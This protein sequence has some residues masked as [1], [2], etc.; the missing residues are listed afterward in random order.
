M[1]E[2]PI[3]PHAGPTIDAAGQLTYVGD[4]GRRYVVG[5]PP[6]VDEASIE[7]VMT[8]LRSGS[9]LFRQIEVLCHSWITQVS[10]DDLEDHAA[11]VLLLTTL[12]TTLEESYP[13]PDAEAG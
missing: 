1:E 2:Q 11:L 7:R 12:E 8:L 6:E 4:D 10:G 9:A 13:E 5:L 3:T